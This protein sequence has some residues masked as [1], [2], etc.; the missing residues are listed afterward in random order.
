MSEVEHRRAIDDLLLSNR[1]NWDERTAVHLDAYP[2]EAFKAGHST[3]HPIEVAEVGAVAGKT[4]LHLQCHFGL[5]TLSWARLGARVTGVDFSEAAIDAARSLAGELGIAGRFLRSDVYALP[6][7]L[8]ERFDIV[9]TSYGAL[10]WLPDIRRWAEV[11]AQF[12]RPGGFLYV[13]D[14]HPL[15]HLIDDSGER[16]RPNAAY[17]DR[18]P[19]RVEQ[20]GSY[21]GEPTAFEHPVNYQWQHTLGDITSAVIDAGLHLEFLHE[22]PVA[23]YQAFESM[24]RGEDGYWR[25]PGNRWPLLFSLWARRPE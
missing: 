21:V 10:T 17:F 16:L 25:Q 9:F 12:V 1:A 4:L 24:E 15:M 22:W 13:I 19:E 7:L 5:D 14:G 6:D 8:D 11:A 23:E 18:A 20:H 3:L 2:V